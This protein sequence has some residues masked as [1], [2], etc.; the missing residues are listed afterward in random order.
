MRQTNRD[1]EPG[2]TTVA[3]RRPVI[4]LRI[5]P[6]DDLSLSH[7]GRLRTA[8]LM[9]RPRESRD[10]RLVSSHLVITPDAAVTLG[11]GCARQRVA[12]A[13]LRGMAQNLVVDSLADIELSSAAWPV[14]DIA[15]SAIF[16]SVSLFRR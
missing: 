7:G 15:A 4:A 9:L 5:P 14:F 2:A 3:A 10:L 13:S 11:A 1:R 16:L 6:Q 8:L 12:T